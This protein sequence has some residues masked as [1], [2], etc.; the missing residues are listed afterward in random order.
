MNLV[1]ENAVTD[2]NIDHWLEE[3]TIFSSPVVE[4]SAI[5]IESPMAIIEVDTRAEINGM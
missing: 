2:F 5:S 3:L 4:E 1:I